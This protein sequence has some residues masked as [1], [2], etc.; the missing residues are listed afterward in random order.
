MKVNKNLR[1]AIFEVID[2]QNNDNNPAETALTL[3]RLRD[4][5]H[6]EFE[7]KQLIG[8]AIAVELF[9][10]MKKNVPFNEARYIKNLKKPA[11]RTSWNINCFL[12]RLPFLTASLTHNDATQE[13]FLKH[14]PLKSVIIMRSS[15]ST[16]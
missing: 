14:T 3:K 2:N 1:N 15:I 12:C 11:Q 16:Y 13:N 9:Y 5:G 6:S 8:Q 10:V 4:E 7:A